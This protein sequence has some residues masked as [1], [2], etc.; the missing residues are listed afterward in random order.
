VSDFGIT[1]VHKIKLFPLS[2][3]ST[4]INWFV[5]LP[6][7]SIDTW[8]QLEQKFHDY[9]YNEE[10][11]LRLSHLVSVKQKNNGSVFDYM[12]R[13]MDTTNRCYGLTISEK[14]LAELAF[15]GLSGALKDKMEDQE[16]T[17]TNQVLQRAVVCENRAKEHKS[18]SQFKETST[19]EKS[20]VNYVDESGE[21]EEETEVCVAEWVDNQKD[22][23]LAC[24]F[25]RLIPR[26]KD[27]IKFTFDV[28][29]CDKLFDVLLQ[30]NVIRLSKGHIIPPPGQL[31]KTKY[32]K[33]HG[34]YS[35]TTNEC[36]YFH[37]QVQLALNDSQLTMGDGNHMRLN[38]DPFLTN[39]SLINFEE[40]KVLVCTSQADTT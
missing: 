39:V 20:V 35:H 15:A 36:N 31:S 17:D 1:D 5:L 32:C 10:T 7:N 11:E 24:S 16:F 9:F 26:K 18:Y 27:E 33:W 22:K 38:T 40:K 3:S 6:P 37:R 8:E 30:N 13:F 29:K 23:P 2:L 21:S 28:M 19:K 34:T 12:R 4:A 14:D 25:L